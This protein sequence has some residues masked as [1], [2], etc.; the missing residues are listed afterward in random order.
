[1]AEVRYLGFV[2]GQ[3]SIDES[4]SNDVL[5]RFVRL[6]EPM[7]VGTLVEV[8]GVPHRIRRVEEGASTGCF[9]LALDA[10]PRTAPVAV[11]ADVTVPSPPPA[12]AAE[13]DDDNGPE[14]GAPTPV[15]DEPTR[16]KGRRRRNRKTVV[17]R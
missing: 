15:A 4:R 8:D 6:S 12:E 3:G 9:V 11:D 13:A 2:V 16:G 17:G 14:D 5:G 1:M 7:P 10:R